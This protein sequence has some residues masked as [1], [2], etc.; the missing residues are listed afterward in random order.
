MVYSWPYS[1]QQF[2]S[3][4]ELK[5]FSLKKKKFALGGVKDIFI[6]NSFERCVLNKEN[7]KSNQDKNVSSSW[8]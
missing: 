1:G 7:S 4:E 8:G 3:L 6:Y 2:I 5:M